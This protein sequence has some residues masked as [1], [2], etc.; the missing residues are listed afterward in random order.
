MKEQKIEGY[1][2]SEYSPEYPMPEPNVLSEEEAKVIYEL[3]LEKEKTAGV[4]HFKGFTTS[5]LTR[6]YMGSREYWTPEWKWPE[7]FAKHYVLDHRVKPTGEFL[8]Y[9]GYKK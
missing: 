6:E 3:I 9:I 5:R 2:F 4:S 8:K 7:D 1:W